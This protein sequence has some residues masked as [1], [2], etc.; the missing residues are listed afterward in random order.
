LEELSDVAARFTAWART[1][2][3]G[4]AGRTS[5]A[6]EAARTG[7]PIAVRGFVIVTDAHVGALLLAGQIAE[8]KQAA[9]FLR[10]RTGNVSGAAH[11]HSAPVQA[12]AALGAG[13]LDAACALLEPVIDT[14]A[15][16][17]E[18]NGWR[19]RCQILYTIALAM[20]GSTEDAIAALA[21]LQQQRHAGW[22]YLNY[23]YALARAWVAA[24]EGAVSDAITLSLSA[25]QIARTNGQFAA[26]VIC[27]QTATQ[28]GDQSAAPRLR[29][30]HTMVEGPR[31]D[32]AARF[33]EA[34]HGGDAAAL[35]SV[36]EKFENAGDLIAAL[37][38]AAHAA[39]AYRRQDKRGSALTCSTR[40]ES[41]AEQCGGATT[42]ALRQACERLPFTDREREVVM[43][44]REGLSNRDI[45]ARLTVSVRT[46]ESHVYNAM[47]K[48]DTATRDD[49]AA[50]MCRRNPETG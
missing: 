28:F 46:V 26:E 6:V 32:I 29:K 50:L 20:R 33:A 19:Y 24:C 21:T 11:L 40:A 4:D 27:L 34:L 14:L 3:A 2:A 47:T 7:Y 38:A 45:A 35:A 17:G 15:A 43:L 36:S 22:Q 37:D 5:E 16:S 18:R 48:T 31:A 25:A 42:P 30:L 10:E 12:R 44:L 13:R 9:E 1:V 41:L 8:A 39:I 49:L 23:E